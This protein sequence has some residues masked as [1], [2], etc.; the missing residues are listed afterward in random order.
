[1]IN[2][3]QFILR[4]GAAL[5]IAL[6]APALSAQG[7]GG[8]N[9]SLSP[10]AAAPAD[11][12]GYW[13]SIVVEDWRYRMLPP[14]KLEEKPVL[15]A[16]IGIPMNPEARKVALAWDPAKEEA[17]GE[18]CKAYGAANIMRIPGRIHVTWQDDQTLKI[19]TD[20]GM[21][22][23]LF[24]FGSPKAAGGTWQGVSQAAWETV[25]GGRGGP[26]P[27]GSLRVITS[28]LKPGYLQKNGIPY[29][30]NAVVREFY[31]RVDEPGASYLVITTTVED[32]TYLTEPYL[33][34]VHFKHQADASGWNPLPCSAR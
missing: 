30:A 1:M 3:K 5:V 4:A 17:A 20:A 19:E 13:E 28:K 31:D 24:E 32:P 22:A 26:I 27:T 16:R 2:T 7:R 12:T 23:R 14:T 18:Q 10:K 21:Q 8:R 9:V 34:S 15:G 11:F 29:S 33:T 6:M 25:P